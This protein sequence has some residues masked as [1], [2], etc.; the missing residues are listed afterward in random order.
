MGWGVGGGWAGPPVHPSGSLHVSE[1]H[2][3]DCIRL[4]SFSVFLDVGG[5]GWC[6]SSSSS[7]FWCIPLYEPL[8][9][10][11]HSL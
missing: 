11:S 3:H 1:S 4:I 7:Q 9:D 8:V 6:G 2:V 10:P 5:S